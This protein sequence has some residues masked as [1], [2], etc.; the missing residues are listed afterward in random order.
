[1]HI[2]GRVRPAPAFDLRT[3]PALGSSKHDRCQLPLIQASRSKSSVSKISLRLPVF[4][5]DREPSALAGPR[6]QTV[7]G[8]RVE[9]RDSRGTGGEGGQ[10]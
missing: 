3:P 5:V 6:S 1:M 9:S 8:A 7:K 2:E 4:F 10:Q